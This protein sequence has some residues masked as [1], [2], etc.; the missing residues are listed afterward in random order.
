MFGISPRRIKL[1]DSAKTYDLKN[2][3]QQDIGAYVIITYLGFKETDFWLTII[4]EKK[5]R[6]LKMIDFNIMNKAPSLDIVSL[7]DTFDG[8]LEFIH[9]PLSTIISGISTCIYRYLV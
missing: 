3:C 7:T 2:A 1:I 4:G 6:G 8:K 5:Q 9:T